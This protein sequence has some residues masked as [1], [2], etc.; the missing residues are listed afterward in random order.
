MVKLLLLLIKNNFKILLIS[1]IFCCNLLAQDSLKSAVGLITQ[2]SSIYRGTLTWPKTSFFPG[3]IFRYKGFSLAGPN[4][5]YSNN[6]KSYIHFKIGV[7]YFDDGS[8]WISFGNAETSK[9]D[10]RPDS[11]MLSTFISWQFSS[12]FSLSGMFRREAVEYK[13]SDGHL[14]FIAKVL[15]FTKIYYLQSWGEKSANL[16]AYGHGA[17][18]GLAYREVGLKFFLPFFFFKSMLSLNLSRSFLRQS[19]DF[20]FGRNQTSLKTIIFRNF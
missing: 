17:K 18:S 12:R 7:N 11:L 19:G 1:S 3:I 13:G 5:S 4:L 2:S 20:V 14:S 16:Y 10:L 9:Y 15:P 6:R 8:P